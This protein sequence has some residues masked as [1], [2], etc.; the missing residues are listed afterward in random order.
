MNKAT[1][2]QI[3]AFVAAYVAAA[4]QAG[5]WSP[6]VDSISGLIEKV[7]ATFTLDDGAFVDRLP[8]LGGQMEAGIL[9]EYAAGLIPADA[10]PFD[11]SSSEL[12]P[13]DPVFDEP[14][15]SYVLKNSNGEPGITFKTTTR[16]EWF[17]RYLAS[18][19]E[20]EI[21]SY[22]LLK[23][24]NSSVSYKYAA[25]RQLLGN[26]IDK[27]AAAQAGETYTTN[28]TVPKCGHIYVQSSKFYIMKKNY[29][30][31]V[32]KSLA[33]LTT[34]GDAVEITPDLV[35]VVAKPVDTAT[36]EAFIKKV[37]DAV[38]KVTI[39]ETEG[40]SLSGSTIGAVRDE[41]RLYVLPGIESVLDVDTLAGAFHVDKLAIPAILKTIPDFGTPSTSN[42]Y[43]VLIDVRGAKLFDN[44]EET[45][46]T[47]VNSAMYVNWFRH[48]GETGFISKHTAIKVFKAS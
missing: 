38:E 29:S 44:Y 14:F 24:E 45:L 26:V 8:E 3:K 12:T 20:D 35:E 27:A 42:V 37:K 2:A 1:I 39:S 41:L 25:K 15:Y 23:L 28:S 7:K 33:T 40:T 17:K 16:R 11:G 18:G 19:N 46:A 34:D 47:E 6:D 22:I 30:A 31:A 32:N 43:A 9:E 13:A 48:I 5:S 21:V 4:K 10:T 36:G